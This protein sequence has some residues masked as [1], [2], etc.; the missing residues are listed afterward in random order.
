MFCSCGQSNSQPSPQQQSMQIA[1]KPEK[2]PE[3]LKVIENEIES[4]IK[5][6]NGPAVIIKKESQKDSS[7]GSSEQKGTAMNNVQ[8]TT[9]ENSSQSTQK[10]DSTAKTQDQQSNTPGGQGSQSE[11]SAAISQKQTPLQPPKPD[12][13]KKA[14]PLVHEM[15][16]KWNNY[17]PL[18]MTMGASKKL[19]DSFSSSLNN[20]T[21]TVS[22]KD[23]AATLISA[24]DLYA[25]I[26][27][28][29]SLYRTKTSPEI[30]KIRYYLRDAMFSAKANNWE[31][32]DLENNNIK[33]SWAFYKNTLDKKEQSISDKLDSS[34]YEFG[35]VVKEKNKQ[36]VDLKG[37]VTISNIEALEKANEKSSK[38]EK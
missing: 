6:L 2:I 37:R 1:Q 11:K 21:N 18:A 36:L 33:S 26:P 22:G 30:K 15:H 28:F 8:S 38:S 14:I 3:Q 24:N 13:W 34:I 16:Y 29:C 5:T 9:S 35:K 19:I 32:A 12:P 20:L 31:K 7:S 23:E 17:M 25:Y 10:Q 4:L 27:D